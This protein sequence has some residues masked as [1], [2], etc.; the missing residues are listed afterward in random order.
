MKT[1]LTLFV[2]VI[3][4]TLFGV[5]CASTPKGPP[6]PNAVQWNGHWYGFIDEKITWVEAE[7]R[8]KDM[9]GH[10]AVVE[11]KEENE[12]VLGYLQS[13]FTEKGSF[14]GARPLGLFGGAWIGASAE[15]DG[16][17]RWIT[18]NGKKLSETYSNWWTRKQSGA[19]TSKYVH[20]SVIH[21]TANAIG[22]WACHLTNPDEQ[23]GKL[24]FIC[25]WE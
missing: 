3:V 9:G 1:K 10:L 8:C 21:S 23:F 20:I 5:G 7:K 25:E 6:M 16:E 11:S 2:A 14:G 13:V 15:V 24:Q 22:S 4:V 12:F 19:G 17:Y 18:P